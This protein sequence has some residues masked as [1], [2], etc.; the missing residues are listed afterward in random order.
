MSDQISTEAESSGELGVHDPT[1]VRD[2]YARYVNEV[3]NPSVPESGGQ[4][5][6]SVSH[7]EDHQGSVSSSSGFIRT[8]VAEEYV[9]D[10][11][12]LSSSEEQDS[13]IPNEAH[14]L[15]EKPMLETEELAKDDSHD[16]FSEKDTRQEAITEETHDLEQSEGNASVQSRRSSTQNANDFDQFDLTR[17]PSNVFMMSEAAKPIYMRHGSED[18]LIPL[19][20]VMQALVSIVN[21][22]D[23]DII[24]SIEGDGDATIVFYMPKHLT[25]VGVVKGHETAAQIKVRLTYMYNQLLTLISPVQL[26]SLF[27]RRVNYDLRRSLVG[28]TRILTQLWDWMDND[29]GHLLCAAC[30]L[31]VSPVVREAVSQSVAHYCKKQ[32]VLFGLVLAGYRLVTIVR[33]NRCP[34]LNP[35]DLQLLTNL[36]R[37]S[38]QS[39]VTGAEFWVPICLPRLDESAYVH[40][41]VSHLDEATDLT[42]VLISADGNQ[43][44][45][46]CECRRKIVEVIT[47]LQK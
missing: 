33:H 42:L 10:A 4:L 17:Y 22:S 2:E 14:V 5:K 27:T 39:G 24:Q 43:F 34:R 37:S 23:G 20:G 29:I 36:V 40:A 1:S 18:R 30:C 46:L 45:S 38:S 9:A 12:S 26:D 44:Y 41:Y 11:H 15:H 47:F 25:I 35:L 19:A 7:S 28:E 32:K 3:I 13:S 31:P 16:S 21:D 8:F 6:S